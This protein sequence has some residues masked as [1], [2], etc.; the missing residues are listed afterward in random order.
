MPTVEKKNQ[1]CRNYESSE[2]DDGSKSTSLCLN[3][4]LPYYQNERATF[5]PTHFMQRVMKNNVLGAW[6]RIK[7]G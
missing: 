4:F 1:R 5:G 6:Q 2:A 3:H 7:R